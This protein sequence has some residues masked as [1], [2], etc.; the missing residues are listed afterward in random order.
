SIKVCDDE[1]RSSSFLAAEISLSLFLKKKQGLFFLDILVI[2]FSF[3]R[4]NN[5]MFF[6]QLNNH[7]LSL[8]IC[9]S[10]SRN[11]HR[12]KPQCD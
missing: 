10:H 4:A 11:N 2:L 3:Q 1:H 7:N 12:T 8:Y 9:Q 6:Q 5:V